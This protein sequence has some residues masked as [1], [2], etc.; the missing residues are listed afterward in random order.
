MPLEPVAIAVPELFTRVAGGHAARITVL[1]PNRR[2]AQA[3][4]RDY[5]A[6][7]QAAGERA[8]ETADILP[9]DAF[10]QRLWEDALYS[11]AAA[12]VPL[13]LGAAQEQAL[14]EDAIAGSRHAEGMLSPAA[15]AAQCRDAWALVH[16]WR[17]AGRLARFE[18][19]EDARAFLEWTGRYSRAARERRMTDA[20]RLPDVVA[21]LLGTEGVRVPAAVVL[22]GF[23]IVTPQQQAFLEALAARGCEVL[24]ARFEP[25]A[26]R[27]G[28][29]AASR[30]E[31]STA[32]DELAEVARWARAR[33]EAN[34]TARI[35]IV[36]PD[37]AQAR[38]RVSRALERVL[39][40]GKGLEAGMAASPFDISLGIPLDQW[41]LV[42]DALRLL[43][44][45]GREVRFEDASRILR[46]PFIAAA[47]AE[48][49]LRA[50]VDAA[51]RE[52]AAALVSLDGLLALAAGNGVPRA[53]RLLDLLAA[54]AQQRR[55]AHFG[56]H[57][58]AEW[59]H[60]FSD[61][62]RIA[63]FPGDRTLDSTEHQALDKWHQLLAA[64]A[65]LERV[66]G[67][68][69]HAEACA[70][71]ERMARETLFQPESGGGPIQVL[72]VLESAGLA[73]DHLWVTGLADDAWPMAPRPN[74]LVPTAL[75]RQAGVPHADAA[76]SLELDRRITAG[77]LAAA[78]EVVMSHARTQ[79]DA[80]AAASPLV[81][82]LPL[83]DAL[84]Q[85]IGSYP[86]L[87][88]VM[89]G[90]GRL[91]RLSDA[92]GSALAP[93]TQAGGTG[94]FK[95]QAACPFRAFA[96][97][98]LDSREL[99]APQPGLDRRDR[100][101]LLH[102]MM[103]AAWGV[104]GS[105]SQLVTLDAAAREA[106]LGQAADEA[107]ERLRRKRAQTLTPRFA[108]LERA[109]LV[110]TGR[111]WLELEETRRDF[112]VVAREEKKLVTF[113]G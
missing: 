67:K 17:L 10:V 18:A 22:F 1:T 50:R 55:A 70:R 86:T 84:V 94:L 54:L 80:E 42:S 95:D 85:G 110:A 63:G 71:L 103:R 76:L 52:R 12:E 77:W 43:R 37:L 45:C 25:R 78:G 57:G 49:A 35:G 33:V 81:T 113:G 29:A 48:M 46:S 98:R 31:F 13:L 20:A 24:S 75:Q 53:S 97:R 89:R 6:G 15:A 99:A 69:R 8:W 62:L 73:F 40:P 109:R 65:S 14:W 90:A 59:A 107:I 30:R 101:T 39:Q 36:V 112:E 68:M 26:A 93:G 23:D 79:D 60:A 64:F 108:A 47:A 3:V 34:P 4:Q 106:L 96:R 74:P 2:L 88:D 7:R 61:T 5:D 66:T 105:R 83:R 41:P 58:A 27:P 82:H 16:G 21:P 28:S 32:E 38:A 9:F 51:L 102:E 104:I 19:G 92:R 72:G 111:E 87:R 91:E 44:L 11:P 100:G 56:A